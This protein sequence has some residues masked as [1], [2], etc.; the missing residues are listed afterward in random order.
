MNQM[1]TPSY[2]TDE[3]TAQPTVRSRS[4]FRWW[5]YPIFAVLTAVHLTVLGFVVYY[6]IIGTDWNRT[7][8]ILL[9]LL[10]TVLIEFVIWEWRWLALPLMRVPCTMPA[11]S[12]W[13]IAAAVTFVPDAESVEMLEETVRAVIAIEY[14]HDTW[15]LDEG[16]D[17]V[18]RGLL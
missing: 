4:R 15:V 10:G 13:R 11:A 16:D 8:L 7:H 2:R 3:D 17:R 9:L 12:G 1:K 5:D 18:V 6:W 14:P